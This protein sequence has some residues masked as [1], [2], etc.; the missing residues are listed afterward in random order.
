MF[1]ESVFEKL[2]ECIKNWLAEAVQSS[3]F[4]ANNMLGD[5]IDV[6]KESVTETPQSWNSTLFTQLQNISNAAIVPIAVGIMAII[7]CYDFITAC[8]DQNNMKDFDIAI[9]FRFIIKAWIAIFFINNVFTISGG[10][11]EIGSAVADKAMITLFNENIAFNDVIGSAELKEML[12]ECSIG[13]LL[14][15][16]IL[17][18]G[19]YIITAAV[20]I[21][22][23]IVTAGRMIE[24]LIYFC[25]APIPFATMTNKEW[26]SV[27]FSYIKNLFALA[28]Q[29]FFIVI[30][31]AIYVILFNTNV[32]TPSEF[33][34]IELT[35]SMFEWICYSVVCCFTLLKSGN[36]A[37]S[38]CGAH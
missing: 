38:I 27:G 8:A 37:K 20:C 21:I 22:I 23:L 3:L 17:S 14:L 11:F 26:S 18:F 1:G 33:E 9:F 2:E 19:V 24:I 7:I 32:M 30:I 35:G 28:L 36:F 31:V 6:M 10:I 25:G 16:L 34:Y 5:M 12:M 15:T 29:A 4:N 13:D